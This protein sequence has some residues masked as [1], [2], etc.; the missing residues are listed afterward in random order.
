MGAMH[1]VMPTSG[2]LHDDDHIMKEISEDSNM[3]RIEVEGKRRGPFRREKGRSRIM[4]RTA[5]VVI[6]K[7][8]Q[9]IEITVRRHAT[10]EEFNILHGKLGAH[11]TTSPNCIVYLVHGSS[12][13]KLGML[14]E[15]N[16]LKLLQLL[17][18]AMSSNA[19]VGLLL[20]DS[21]FGGALHKPYVHSARFS[22]SLSNG[23]TIHHSH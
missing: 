9:Q 20:I 2:L 5:N 22:R 1:L 17:R 14:G 7:R 6:R 12:R 10:E 3:G 18:D 16:L 15:I 21:H 23:S 13:K 11:T 19:T 4:S 8:R